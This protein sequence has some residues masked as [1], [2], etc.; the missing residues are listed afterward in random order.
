MDPRYRDQIHPFKTPEP[1]DENS[2]EGAVF[3]TK[4]AKTDYL[5]MKCGKLEESFMRD[6]TRICK[7][8]KDHGEDIFRIKDQYYD[9]LICSE[10]EVINE[11]N[12]LVYCYT[13]GPVCHNME[14]VNAIEKIRDFRYHGVDIAKLVGTYAEIIISDNPVLDPDNN[15]TIVGCSVAEAIA[16]DVLRQINNKGIDVINLISR[17]YGLITSRY[18]LLDENGNIALGMSAIPLCDSIEDA[19]VVLL[20]R[21]LLKN[22]QGLKFVY[23]CKVSIRLR[24][25]R[26]GKVE[27]AVRQYINGKID[28]NYAIAVG[29]DACIR[30]GGD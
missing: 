26:V 15:P 10:E 4:Y 6:R 21:D 7:E 19:K 24:S 3:G 14:E 27:H 20:W 17:Y 30:V 25:A 8:L 22:V 28:D 12:S 1:P 29:H 2:M 13:E 18:E 5:I 9:W 11:K 16:I 23:D